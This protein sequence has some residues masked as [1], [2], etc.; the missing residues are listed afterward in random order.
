MTLK[1]MDFCAGIGGG[2]LGLEEN[3]F[4]CI[5]YSEID[6]NTSKTYKIFYGEK[7]KNYGDLMNINIENLPDF[8][9]MIAGFPCQTFSIAGKRKGMDDLRGQVIYGLMNILTEKNISYFIFEN[10][11]GLVN[12]DNGKTIDLILEELNNVGYKVYS[13]VLDSLN[14]GIPQMR[15]RVYFV[16]IKKDLVEDKKDFQFP[17]SIELNKLETF[18]IDNNNIVLNYENDITF[19]KYLN[20]KYNAGKFYL[21]EILKQDYLVL[22][23]RQSDLR[24]YRGKIPTLRTGR[25][26]ILYVKDKKLKKLSGYEALL[27][28]GFPHEIVQKSIGNVV[29]SKLLSQAGNAMSVTTV[30]QIGK[31]LK[32]YIVSRKI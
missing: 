2:R 14:Y 8:D 31:A 5:A 25:H 9:I 28:Q 27:L 10:V 32:N 3:G 22:D 12:H 17:N 15:E 1:F 23:T 4:K 24:I 20:N 7:E 6:E 21:N 13:K 11:K 19:K 26:G 30:S 16:G 18:L 29:G